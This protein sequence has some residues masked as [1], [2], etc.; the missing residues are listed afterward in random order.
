MKSAYWVP[1]FIV[2]LVA[3]AGWNYTV[4]DSKYVEKVPDDSI[5]IITRNGKSETFSDVREMVYLNS[6]IRIDRGDQGVKVFR[7]GSITEIE[8]RLREK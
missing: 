4:N 3:V 8:I 2:I 1:V 7:S 5:V 6:W